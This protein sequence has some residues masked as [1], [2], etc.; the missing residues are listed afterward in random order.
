MD[1][2]TF[3]AGLAHL[4]RYPEPLH[5]YAAA[6]AARASDDQRAALLGE[7]RGAYADYVAAQDQQADTQRRAASEL[8]AFASGTL[9][10]LQRAAEAAEHDSAE[11]ILDIG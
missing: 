5:E 6:T 2:P 8:R 11:A 1:L 9:L 4:S 7:L 10:P 3:L